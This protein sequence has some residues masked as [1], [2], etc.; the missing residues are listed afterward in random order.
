M[1]G[2]YQSDR[3][4]VRSVQLDTLIH[5]VLVCS[6]QFGTYR[7]NIRLIRRYDGSIPKSDCCACAKPWD[8]RLGRLMDKC[9]DTVSETRF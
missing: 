6:V 9:Q 1:L 4:L 8:I 3:R 5:H 2:T 7:T